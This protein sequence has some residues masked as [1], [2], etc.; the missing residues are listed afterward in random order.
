[1]NSHNDDR[2]NEALR[3]ATPAEESKALREIADMMSNEGLDH[4]GNPDAIVAAV[5]HLVA[6]KDPDVSRPDNAPHGGRGGRCAWGAIA[7]ACRPETEQCPN[8]CGMAP[9]HGGPCFCPEHVIRNVLPTEATPS[10]IRCGDTSGPFTEGRACFD[11]YHCVARQ[12]KNRSSDALSEDSYEAFASRIRSFSRSNGLDGMGS[13]LRCGCGDTFTWIGTD[14]RL[15]PWVDWHYPHLA[16]RPNEAS[17]D[18][19][20]PVVTD[21]GCW[22]CRVLADAVKAMA[23]DV[24]MY[25]GMIVGARIGLGAAPVLC[26]EHAERWQRVGMQAG[27]SSVFQQA[28]RLSNP[29]S[30]PEIG[31]KFANPRGRAYEVVGHMLDHKQVVVK[32]DD[33]LQD[34]AI[35][36]LM[37]PENGWRRLEPRSSEATLAGGDHESVS[38]AGPRDHDS[39]VVGVSTLTPDVVAEIA[40]NGGRAAVSGSLPGCACETY[41][42]FPGGVRE[43]ASA[44]C[45]LHGPALSTPWTNEAPPGCSVEPYSSRACERGTRS[46][47]VSHAPCPDEATTD[48]AGR[49]IAAWLSEL[50]EG[51]TE[52]TKPDDECIRDLVTRLFI[53]RTD[54][55][56]AEASAE[57]RKAQ[58]EADEVIDALMARQ[59]KGRKIRLVRVDKLAEAVGIES[60]D[61]DQILAEIGSLR[62]DAERWRDEPSITHAQF[63]EASN[64]KPTQG[65]ID[66]MAG[67]P[68][69]R[70]EADENS[71]EEAAVTLTKATSES[72][73]APQGSSQSCVDEHSVVGSLQPGNV[74]AERV[75]M[76]DYDYREHL[77]E[78]DMG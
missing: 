58:T 38:N 60:E 11:A 22:V 37:V 69:R 67:R 72:G 56:S 59:P 3:I 51:I 50:D 17:A 40:H 31:A 20:Q 34:T 10:C 44:R 55:A 32:G 28:N 42:G 61:P 70:K 8:A 9:D 21:L 62:A 43:V 77:G 63:V 6:Q 74:V 29:S 76:D 2:S 33:G 73:S 46:C 13:T 23:L 26:S 65:L 78:D 35:W 4:H 52:P 71:R 36:A 64:A 39:T 18:A 27:L 1:M 53:P 7:P 49:I 57:L 45:P 15:R 75:V 48:R 24:A 16:S 14:D 5:R 25:E 12:R 19:P 68:R 54:K 47:V 66:L 41:V 30:R